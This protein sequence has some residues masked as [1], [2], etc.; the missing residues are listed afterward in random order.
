MKLRKSSLVRANV[1]HTPSPTV[2]VWSLEAQDMGWWKGI[3]V[4]DKGSVAALEDHRKSLEKV[5]GSGR[6]LSAGAPSAAESHLTEVCDRVSIP[7]S[8][9]L[10]NK[11]DETDAPGHG[12]HLD[13]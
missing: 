6:M 3:L 7:P 5:A 12:R 11:R 8:K 4:E 13:D 1:L 9:S 10:H 2:Q